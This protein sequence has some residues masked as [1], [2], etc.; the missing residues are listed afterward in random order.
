MAR[1]L[2]EPG[3]RYLAHVATRRR[4]LFRLLRLL[5][6]FDPTAPDADVVRAILLDDELFDALR[7]VSGPPIS[8]DD[9]AVVVTRS[10]KGMSK[11]DLK[12]SK[13]LAKE[14]LELI[15]RL[16]DPVRFP[17]I[18]QK[19]LPS[20]REI[21]IAIQSTAT[22][23]AAQSLQTERRGFGKEVERHFERRLCALGFLKVSGQNSGKPNDAGTI[24]PNFPAKAQVNQPSHHPAFPHFYGECIVYGRKVDMLI[25][26]KS[27]RIVAL[28][29]KD[30][31]AA[32][33]ST[34]RLLN[35]TAAKAKHYS[36][37]AGRNVISV[38]LLS[39]VF[40]LND[41]I[42]AQDSGLY[43]VWAHN[44]DGFLGWIE[45]QS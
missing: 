40:K 26:L 30:S 4:A 3:G 41:L 15:C 28:E 27:V 36:N 18:G 5:A 25:A 17:W 31:S 6:A 38:A 19:R 23:H 24:L 43:V 44:L 33:N 34:K 8:E 13:T 12:K 39:G 29:A 21:R 10:A 37:A 7:Y 14:V 1:R 45:S 42:A 9:L 22:L 2:A 11:T 20:T 35:D 32:I 16:S